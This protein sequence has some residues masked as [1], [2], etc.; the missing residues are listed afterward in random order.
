MENKVEQQASSN[1]SISLT[2]DNEIAS[3]FQSLNESLDQR[4]PTSIKDMERVAIENLLNVIEIYC[5]EPTP[6]SSILTL[7]KQHTQKPLNLET[8]G[9][10]DI[11]KFMNDKLGKR[12]KFLFGDEYHVIS[13]NS[14]SKYVEFSSTDDENDEDDDE[15]IPA[16]KFVIY[17]ENKLFK[18]RED[19]SY[20]LA[21]H[22][23]INV[24]MAN[25]YRLFTNKYGYKFDCCDYGLE[26]ID[27]LLEYL[28]RIGYVIIT[29]ND[30]KEMLIKL[31]PEKERVKQSKVYFDEH[32]ASKK[33]KKKVFYFCNHS[34]LFL[35]FRE[36]S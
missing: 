34:F 26:T 13:R 16:K 30:E 5:Q 27:E 36:T 12:M 25:F 4:M 8:F 3:Q 29:L 32:I 9:Y 21:N 15:S 7:Y 33:I 22:R 2:K 31:V 28:K 10:S 6:L 17:S 23:N 19:I 18:L 24:P 14:K 1:D 35:N 20:T 11:L